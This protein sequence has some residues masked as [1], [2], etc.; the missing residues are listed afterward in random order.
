M[1]EWQRLVA[2][3]LGEKPIEALT[4]QA[5][6]GIAMNP[7]ASESSESFAMELPAQWEM[8][9]RISAEQVKQ[10]NARA[11]EALMGGCNSLIMAQAPASENEFHA[12][13]EGVFLQYIHVH[14]EQSADWK[15]TADAILN[16]CTAH[17]VNSK[18]LRGSFG[19]QADQLSDDALK[20]WAS[21]MKENFTLFRG[22]AVNAR[23][24]HEEGGS[25]VQEI[26]FALTEG[27]ALLLRCMDAG[28][29]I[30]EAS[31]LMQFNFSTGSSYFTEIAKYRAFRWAWK[32]IIEQYKPAFACSVHT[33]IQ[34]STSRY[35]QTAKDVHNNLL[36]ATTQAMSAA[37]GGVNG[38]LVEPY[39]SWSVAED[40]SALRWSRNIQQL[41]T[42]ESYFEQ[43]RAAASG[44]HYVEGLTGKVLQAGWSLFQQWD[45]VVAAQG[46]EA[47]A[48]RFAEAITLH[49]NQLEAEVA[50]GK[51][52]V[53][54][55]NKYVN[56]ADT[57]VV[58]PS[59]KT[60]TASLE[61]S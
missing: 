12:M 30:D 21:F 55:V 3:E 17:Q 22:F 32:S 4:W 46:H 53:V 26:A 47:F 40:E 2:K 16:W 41:L 8:V 10:W 6:E 56:K 54:G 20:A 1:Q 50:D 43:F 34:A 51:R 25:A 14:V 35:M 19:V 57:S 61:N 11:L 44:S 13:V 38:I 18:E 33:H 59:A 24:V 15:L 52:I 60:L 28:L 37:V 27:H 29:T 31:A 39:N 23:R 58:D 48:A 7:Y 36:R 9:Q 5:D 49:R 45:Q 42:E